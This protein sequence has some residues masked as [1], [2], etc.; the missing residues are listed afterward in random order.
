MIYISLK[1]FPLLY[2][3]GWKMDKGTCLGHVDSVANSI[4]TS[5]QKCERTKV[6]HF[7]NSKDLEFLIGTQKGQLILK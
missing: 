7:P 4:P 5:S 2:F 3:L 6:E 1:N